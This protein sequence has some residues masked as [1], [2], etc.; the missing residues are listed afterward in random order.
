[1]ARVID[2]ILSLK[3]MF[4]PTMKNVNR[5]IEEQ[6]RAQKMLNTST[7]MSTAAAQRH[8]ATLQEQSKIHKR[9]SKD[10]QDTGKSISSFGKMTAAI[11]VPLMAAA[12]AGFQLSQSL[13]KSVARIKMV[14]GLSTSETAQMKKDIMDL[15]NKTGVAVEQ[16]AEATKSIITSGVSAGDSMHYMAD[17]INISKI[18]GSDLNETV[19]SLTK[20]TKAYNLTLED[21]GHLND[22]LIVTARLAQTELKDT[23]PALSGVAKSAADAGISVQ[24]MG[25][26]Y[27]MMVNRG[28]DSQKA[29]S[30]LQSVFDSF[31]K[32]SPKAIKAAQDFGIELNR[33][34]IQAVGFPAFLKEIQEKT[35][36]DE[37]AIG[38]IIKD[39]EGFKLALM[40]ASDDGAS[41]FADNLD[42]I[43]NSTG[44]TAKSLEDMSTPAART[45]KAFNEIRTAGIQLVNGLEP[46]WTRTSTMVKAGVEWFKSLSDGQ[47]GLIF[48]VLQF[49][50]VTTVMTTV[51]GKGV[52]IFGKALDKITATGEAIEKAGSVSGAL[53]TEFAR[54]IS[55]VKKLGSEFAGV[56]RAILHPIT[57]LEKIKGRILSLGKFMQSGV[58][59]ALTAINLLKNGAVA[60][61]RAIGVAMKATLLSPMGIAIAAIVV[62]A[63]L[64]YT[65]WDQIKTYLVRVFNILKENV[66]AMVDRVTAKFSGLYSKA[67][68]VFSKLAALVSGVWAAISSA[69]GGGE[70]TI[71]RVMGIIMN[72]VGAGFIT[73]FN[74][75]L[76]SVETFINVLAAVIGGVLDVLNGIIDF[77]T[78]VF[79]GNWS[80][81]WQGIVE[82]FSGI[83]VTITGVCEAVLG[84]V[85]GAINAV[86]GGI[87]SISVDIPEWVPGVGGSHYAPSIPYLARG[88]ENWRGG[89]AV[90]HDAGPEIV[91]LPS[92]TRVIPHDKSMKQEYERGKADA[93]GAPSISIAKLADSIVIRE[94]SDIDKL[95]RKLADELTRRA[96]N[97]MEGA[98]T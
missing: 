80:Q 46:I 58:S 1:M 73:A 96:G 92:G 33:A 42:R 85:K 78:G 48:D 49:I 95:V 70:G 86:I 88:T 51:V 15:S 5:S 79:T 76:N 38:K 8:G 26:A 44:T 97:Q 47:K 98:T 10:I 64:I 52:K 94:E 4:T 82:I 2:A 30:S 31:S 9:L 59:S 39:V 41:E 17:A 21:Q 7:A 6:E 19:G 71:S 29:A 63:V 45:A 20:F 50:I 24:Q 53:A 12:T 87:N 54:P 18:A 13:D 57:A 11:T 56:G 67:S 91:D 3:D 65:H 27:A 83:F 14:A 55:I 72:V 90:I 93:G 66:G 68:G 89:P 16:V 22:Q 23:I 77:L 81:A 62:L 35:G 74:M 61:F 84:G 37:Q 32:A 25:A 34:H 43:N 28:N 75:A 69:F 40:M 36:G 60:A